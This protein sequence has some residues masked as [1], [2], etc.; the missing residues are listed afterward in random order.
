MALL[1]VCVPPLRVVFV[2]R[3]NQP[4]RGSR[5][6]FWP[7]AAG[8]RPAADWGI[9]VMRGLFYCSA[10]RKLKTSPPESDRSVIESYHERDGIQSPT[11]IKSAYF[12][13]VIAKEGMCDSF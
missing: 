9:T 13:Q 6:G 1:K 2:A 8:Y 5:P 12:T 11:S 4:A 3:T 10:S 7:P